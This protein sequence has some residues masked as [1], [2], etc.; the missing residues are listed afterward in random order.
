MSVANRVPETW[1]LSGD[2]AWETLKRTGRWRLAKDAFRRFRAS[3][4]TSHARSLAFLLALLLVQGIILLVA[5]ASMLSQG[6]WADLFANTLRAV[7]PGPSGEVL[8]DAVEQAQRA[9]NG[10]GGAVLV[11]VLIA[12]VITAA[13]L[14][15]Q[16]ER[17]MNRLYGIERDR[18]TL[19]KYGRALLLSVTAGI[20]TA[21]AFAAIA[22]GQVAATS[23]G[24][25]TAV[26]IWLLLRWP[27]GLVLAI[28]GTALVFR[29]SPFRHQPAWSWL[30][31]GAFVSVGL[32]MLAT[33]GL[34]A[35]FEHSSS[36]GR[37]Y[38]PLAG[39]VALLL[40]SFA[41]AVATLYGAAIA[42]QLEAV[43]AGVPRPLD[44]VLPTVPDRERVLAGARPRMVNPEER[45]P[46]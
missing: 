24:G 19:R 31:F 27:L 44:T 7:A 18:P 41:T 2:D 45:P 22:L 30:T 46:D 39:M 13:S 32:W 35:F 43:R 10:H 21:A 15:G 28:A 40:W 36:F 26:D 16:V 25:G 1:E 42:A 14:M 34:N 5:V 8:T 3:D 6:G 29:W 23:F 17:G 33:V 9:G 11:G 20:L 38:G 12:A 37:T 4:G